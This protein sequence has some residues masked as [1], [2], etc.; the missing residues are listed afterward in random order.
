M[1]RR[2][3][4]KRPLADALSLGKLTECSSELSKLLSTA[5]QLNHY[6]MAFEQLLPPA[7]KGCFHV[8]SISNTHLIITCHSATLATRFRMTQKQVI[9]KLNRQT[10]LTIQ[11]VK[12]KIRPG[13]LQTSTRSTTRVLSKKNAQLLEKAAEQTEDLKLKKILEKLAAHGGK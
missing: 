13:N 2:Q 4:K 6:D 12:V 1:L 11:N 7:L 9:E 3:P 8:N 5:S 10:G